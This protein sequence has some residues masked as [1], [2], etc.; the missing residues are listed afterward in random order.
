[1]LCDGLLVVL[2][3]LVEVGEG[4]VVAVNGVGVGSGGRVGAGSG[5][6]LLGGVGSGCGRVVAGCGEESL[7][8]REGGG[9]RAGRGGAQGAEGVGGGAEH[10]TRVALAGLKESERR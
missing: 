5:C 9:E 6:R 2:E 7:A 1:M 10:G 3:L 8:E 4:G